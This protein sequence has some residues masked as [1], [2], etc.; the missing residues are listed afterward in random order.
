[1][2]VRTPR[3]FTVKRDNRRLCRYKSFSYSLDALCTQNGYLEIPSRLRNRISNFSKILRPETNCIRFWTDW[4]SYSPH[5][6]INSA[7][8]LPLYIVYDRHYNTLPSQYSRISV[9]PSVYSQSLKRIKITPRTI[10]IRLLQFTP[11]I[12]YK[13]WLSYCPNRR[14]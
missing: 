2:E 9:N 14:T 6:K 12:S 7:T 10:D 3:Y 8:N 5:D 11:K 13:R 4:Y 1:M